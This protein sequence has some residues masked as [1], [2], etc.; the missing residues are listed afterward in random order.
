MSWISFVHCRAIR[1][2]QVEMDSGQGSA[3]FRA[4][5]EDID[6]GSLCRLLFG[7]LD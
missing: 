5:C 3:V 6:K 2:D 1:T 7:G 4:L